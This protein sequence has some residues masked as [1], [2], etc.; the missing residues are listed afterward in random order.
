M[1][2]PVRWG[3]LFL[4]MLLA[5]SCGDGRMAASGSSV[6][7][8]LAWLAA[9]PD[10]VSVVVVNPATGHEV[11]AHD[12]D[13]PRPLASVR[14]VLILGAYAEAVVAGQVDPTQLVDLE[15]VQRWWILGTDADA[16]ESAVEEATTEHW[17]RNGRLELDRVV[18]AMVRWS[19]NAAADY[20]LALLGHHRVETF[21]ET[22]D[23][24]TDTTFGSIFGETLAWSQFS[25]GDWEAMTPD[26]RVEHSSRLAHQQRGPLRGLDLPDAAT[27]RR[28]AA[29]STLGTARQW[30]HFMGAV[31]T[32]DG[33]DEDAALIMRR[34][35]EW[36][37][38]AFPDEIQQLKSFG[39]KGGSLAGV[40]TEVSYLQPV[41]E[42]L[43]SVAMFFHDLSADDWMQLTRSLMHQQLLLQ[44]ATDA[45]ALQRLDA[46]LADKAP[47]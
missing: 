16:H 28:L 34:H 41:D 37:L 46:T 45:N 38:R 15:E 12:P 20:L 29:T 9:H 31:A 21:S 23:V 13:V 39:T 17:L 3:T 42:E 7:D 10:K 6:D 43:L 47:R 33:F 11:I 35:L 1:I 25:V 19:D 44:I 24:A 30:A 4:V 14:K 8:L 32:G 36:S 22:H 26:E 18:W 40:V 27:Q 5:P 2:F